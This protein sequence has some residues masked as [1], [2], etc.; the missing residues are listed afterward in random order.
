M[1]IKWQS[2]ADALKEF[3]RRK[4]EVPGYAEQLAAYNKRKVWARSPFQGFAYDP[5][6]KPEDYD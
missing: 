3:E 6:W 5:N 4:R 2:L 1:E